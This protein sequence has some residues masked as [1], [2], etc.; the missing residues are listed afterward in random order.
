MSMRGWIAGTYRKKRGGGGGGVDTQNKERGSGKAFICELL[1]GFDRVS[2][3]L[4][5][6]I[7]SFFSIDN[8]VIRF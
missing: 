5:C 1:L 7:V 4:Q 2:Y 3:L 8:R 6:C